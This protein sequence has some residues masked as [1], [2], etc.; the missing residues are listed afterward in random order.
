MTHDQM[1]WWHSQAEKERPWRRYDQ[2]KEAI[3][4]VRRLPIV[5]GHGGLSNS[6]KM[7]R[8]DIEL[9]R[10][11]F[12]VHPCMKRE[13]LLA[14]RLLTAFREF[15]RRNACGLVPFYAN[16]LAAL[17][18]SLLAARERLFAVSGNEAVDEA[19]VLRQS[20]KLSHIERNV[21]EMRQLKEEEE[22]LMWRSVAAMQQL[23]AEMMDVRLQ[24]GYCATSLELAV[25]QKPPEEVQWTMVGIEATNAYAGLYFPVPLQHLD[26]SYGLWW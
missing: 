9:G 23:Y 24:Q 16:R 20:N 22:V 15:K 26:W 2:D 11:E 6:S 5:E 14:A 18:A 25:L 12:Q 1:T 3:K 13:D 19:E 7:Y 21:A 4:T 17:E 10:L 8:L